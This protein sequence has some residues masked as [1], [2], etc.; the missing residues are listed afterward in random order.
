MITEIGK[1]Y[2]VYNGRERFY[3]HP[4]HDFAQSKDRVKYEL[5]DITTEDT[6]KKMFDIPSSVVQMFIVMLE[7]PNFSIE[8]INLSSVNN[9][10]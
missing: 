1:T 2:F 7:D 8:N 5:Y 3:L 6:P 4:I 9:L 10:C